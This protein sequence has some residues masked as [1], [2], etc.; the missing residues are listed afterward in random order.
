[1]SCFLSQVCEAG[2]AASAA[3]TLRNPLHCT[4]V[5][6]AG[7]APVIIQAMQIHPKVPAMQV[8]EFN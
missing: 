5:M 7:W 3:I 4:M 8:K 2:F 6:E 1:M